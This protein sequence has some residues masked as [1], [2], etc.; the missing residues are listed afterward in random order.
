[1]ECFEEDACRDACRDANVDDRADIAELFA[2]SRAAELAARILDFCLHHESVDVAFPDIEV[3]TASRY[4]FDACHWYGP[5]LELRDWRPKLTPVLCR[6]GEGEAQMA[7]R[8]HHYHLA[9]RQSLTLRCMLKV[10]RSLPVYVPLR[11]CLRG[12]VP[13]CVALRAVG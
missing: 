4:V 3:W 7:L 12:E 1:V 11:L 8:R 2:V 5:H 13:R 9:A 10:L 6:E